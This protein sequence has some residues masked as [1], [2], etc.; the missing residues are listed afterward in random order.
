MITSNEQIIVK[1]DR[2]KELAYRMDHEN[3]V[4]CALVDF[5][6]SSMTALFEKSSSLACKTVI[7]KSYFKV[8]PL[9]NTLVN[10]YVDLVVFTRIAGTS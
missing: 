8:F 2:C 3:S 6:Q 10:V 7:E 4:F 9:Y 1:I 5:S